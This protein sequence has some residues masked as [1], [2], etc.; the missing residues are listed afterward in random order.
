MKKYLI[1]SLVVLVCMLA[2]ATQALATTV[3]PTIVSVTGNTN[4]YINLT[5]STT[6]AVAG[7]FTA[8]ST[9]STTITTLFTAFNFTAT[10]TG[11][12]IMGNEGT[13]TIN[14]NASGLPEGAVKVYTTAKTGSD[15]IS[16]TTSATTVTKD[17]TPP[18]LSNITMYSNNSAST[19]IAK[20]GDTV[21]LTATS[22]ETIASPTVTF[23]K[24]GSV[25]VSNP[26]S[27]GWKSTAVMGSSDTSGLITFN[28][29]FSDSA[30]N[31]GIATTTLNNGVATYYYTA[32]TFSLTGSN[33]LSCLIRT[34]C[35]DPSA[36]AVDSRGISVTL[37]TLS[38]VSTSSIGRYTISYGGVDAAG[39]AATSTRDVYV[40]P[41]GGT[42]TT[43][44]NV[45]TTISTTTTTTDNSSSG[46]TTVT[47]NPVIVTSNPVTTQ[48]VTN[49]EV[50]VTVINVSGVA[51]AITKQL[52]NGVS[53][54]GVK[55]LQVL[56]AK[57]KTI[58]PE[59]YITGHF[60]NL[61]QKAVQRFQEK[62]NIVS[63]GQAGYGQV[64]PKTKAKLIEIYG[65]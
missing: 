7:T 43:N 29:S 2:I 27:N 55:L 34:A 13:Y 63:K 52:K 60:G 28:M 9:A 44:T 3:T 48:V 6:V 30:G 25:T 41:K 33:P 31:A 35:A 40:A 45:T 12:I 17:V 18:T 36:T 56:L 51:N 24:G 39:N 38:N 26:A 46:S 59:G 21:A 16:A 42:V 58:Y 19:T 37:S 50:P 22:S 8:S 57:D 20:V 49:S 61:T 1:L 5:G 32:P 10:S 54:A 15:T 65:E 64:G 14:I 53:N 62:Y 47:S 23:N 4:G 11:S